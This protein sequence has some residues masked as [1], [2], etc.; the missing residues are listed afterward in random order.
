ML[1]G[2]CLCGGVQYEADTDGSVA[3]HCHCTRCQ[4]ASGS[5]SLPAFLVDTDKLNIVAGADQL[6]T[7]A[8]EGFAA[9][10]F[11]KTCGSGIYASGENFT[12][13]NAGTLVPGSEFKPQFHMMVGSKAS[14]EEITDG[15][16]Q[17]PEYPPMG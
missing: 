15:L 2:G 7:Y 13:V 11:C 6:T 1:K 17:F 5:G 14:W 4:R 12:V 3:G 10:H 8:E 9:R 16:T